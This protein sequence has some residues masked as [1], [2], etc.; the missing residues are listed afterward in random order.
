M[1]DQFPHRAMQVEELY[2]FD[3]IPTS[4]NKR[5]LLNIFPNLRVLEVEYDY[6]KESYNSQP[7]QIKQSTSKLKI[8][9]D[10]THCEI[11]SQLLTSNLADN[12]EQLH[13]YF[14]SIR[15][16]STRNLLDQL[17]NLLVLSEL[18]LHSVS[19]GINDMEN[20]HGNIP[21]IHVFEIYD[22]TIVD[23]KTPVSISPV[24]S[25]T[26]LNI[27]IEYADD[28]ETHIQLYQYMTE[29]YCK[30]DYIECH[31]GRLSNYN[32]HSRKRIYLNG[33]MDFYKMTAPK[34]TSFNIQDVPHGVNILDVVDEMGC[35]LE[36]VSISNCQDEML[37]QL[38]RSNQSRYIQKL[39]L[40]MT[41]LGS[42]RSIK[43]MEALTTLTLSFYERDPPII[44]L[45]DCLN[46]CP[47]TLKQFMLFCHSI[48]VDMSNV[49]LNYIDTLEIACNIVDRTLADTISSCFPK[50]VTLNLHGETTEDICIT[51]PN[52]SFQCR[53]L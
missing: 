14:E 10:S 24:T 36:D 20:I 34:Q 27:D 13:L 31:D 9:H 26:T 47:P 42:I 22:F 21:G 49:H 38:P 16:I 39:M 29:K 3:T 18:I 19:L 35:K 32:D 25:I 44:D 11:T 43:S 30:V 48:K 40:K 37:Q 2:L 45:A 4:F 28:A 5:T 1:I 33:I 41:D 8:L 6:E 52:L 51:L 15:S 50:L 12:L 23:S 46:A 17:S 53:P 7:I